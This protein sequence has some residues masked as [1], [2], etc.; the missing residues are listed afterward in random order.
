V[1]H[2]RLTFLSLLLLL[3]TT[4]IWTSNTTLIFGFPAW[5]LYVFASAIIYAISIAWL[6]GRYWDRLASHE[7]A[8]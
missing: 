8:N 6:L 2:T 4:P 5:S 1:T 7:S 3:A